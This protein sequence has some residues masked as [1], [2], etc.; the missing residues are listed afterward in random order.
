[1][2]LKGG[3]EY[4]TSTILN[5][6]SSEVSAME[7]TSA[8]DIT[9]IL[10]DLLEPPPDQMDNNGKVKVQ[11]VEKNNE[12]AAE[13]IMFAK[14]LMN[15]YHDELPLAN[16]DTAI[17]LFQ[18][19]L[20]VCP[21]DHPHHPDVVIDLASALGMR[22]V[23]TNRI[24]DLEDSLGLRRNLME[25]ITTGRISPNVRNIA[26]IDHDAT[27]I[28]Q[29]A[30]QVL[31][32]FRDSAPPHAVNSI[33]F[34]LQDVLT[35]ESTDEAL[36]FIAF[37]TLAEGLFARFSHS[38]IILDL[39][40]AISFQEKALKCFNHLQPN[41]WQQQSHATL[42]L[43][44]MLAARF[45]LLKDMDDLDDLSKAHQIFDGVV[46]PAITR[47]NVGL[48]NFEFANDLAEQFV[49]S[50]DTNDLNQ[51]IELF[52]EANSYFLL[53]S[54]G[55]TAT[56]NNLANALGNRFRQEG[57]FSDLEES[58]KL[59]RN[60]LK[61][62]PAHHPNRYLSLI[63]LG[64]ALSMLFEES[65]ERKD[66][67]EA[68]SHLRQALEA[69]ELPDPHRANALDNI[70]KA[71]STRFHEARQ[72]SDLDEAISAHKHAL[73]LRTPPDPDRSLT[74]NGLGV[75]VMFRF[76]ESDNVM[77]LNNA[78]S[79][80]R[81][82]LNLRP[83]PHPLRHSSL[84]NLSAALVARD[85]VDPE[86][87]QSDL[88]EAI[89]YMREGLEVQAPAHSHR[90]TILVSLADALAIRF[91]KEDQSIRS[92]DLLEAISLYKQ[93][94]DL[95]T[96]PHPERPGTLRRLAITLMS[97]HYADED[98]PMYIDMAMGSF[99]EAVNCF[100]DSGFS[101]HRFDIAK[102]WAESADV[103]LH[104]SAA[105]A[106]NVA[107][108]MLPQI[109]ALALNVESR[110]Q[111]LTSISDGLARKAARYF[112][113]QGNADRAIEYL[114]AGRVIFWSQILHLRSPFDLL[115][116][117]APELEEKLRGIATVLEQA[118][119][120]D[121]A[122]GVMDNGTKLRM[123]EDASRLNCLEQEWSKAIDQVR[124][125]KGFNDFLK[126]RGI[127]SLI[128]AAKGHPIVILVAN[129]DVSNCM[130]MTATT[131]H[132]LYL[133]TLPSNELRKL[134]HLTQAAAS[135]TLVRRSSLEG[136]PE[137][138]TA[139]NVFSGEITEALRNWLTLE[140][141]ERG[142][143]YEN[144]KPIPSEDIFRSVLETLW[145][146]VVKPVIDFLKLQKTDNPPVLKWCPTGPFSFLPLHGAGRYLNNTAIEC[147]SDY[148]ISSYTPTIGML[149]DEDKQP[150]ISSEPFQIMAVMDN[151]RLPCARRELQCI[152]S[153][154][155]H[156]CLVEYGS[157]R[158]PANVDAVF[159]G[160]STASIVHF[161]CHGKQDKSK[162]LNS[163]LLLEDGS[164]MVSKIM[165]QPLPQGSL[166]FLSACETGT[167]DENL[168]DEA[169]SLGACLLFSGFRN[170]VA[171]M[172]EMTDVDGPTV[173]DAFYEHL[174]QGPDGKPIRR[175]DMKKSAQA[176]HVSVGKLRSKGVSFRRWLPFIHMGK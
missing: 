128:S 94:V 61:L 43:S 175:P 110:Q 69:R 125:L 102:L 56:L 38:D 40:N 83:S 4:T 42:R 136:S 78:I 145:F 55:D 116:D 151:K 160:L 53:G 170:V 48:Y 3:V 167:G 24:D 22:F 84:R 87:Q 18:Q 85:K 126:P 162:P 89:R 131:G 75:A 68:I 112:I 123:E 98:N 146:K 17:S 152:K 63:G 44:A 108:Q 156:D 51:A 166:A 57:R 119:H 113:Q 106:Y 60:A 19:A 45:D 115:H 147:A 20:E 28:V 154:V 168:P 70:G 58:I 86:T 133:P 6:L 79:W 169:M 117:T 29:T 109:A 90:S 11:V 174:F 118:S 12:M 16:L 49:E 149:L 111:S 82:A 35:I 33:I 176:L 8:G 134:V 80:F 73:Q 64:N 148:F 39:H 95:Q 103:M 10:D 127:L 165:Q 5:P 143:K 164:L 158:A 101:F 71:L 31:H 139:S 150:N 129:N 141:D 163:S 2:R 93:A 41:Q 9:S 171:T 142:M 114:E 92:K 47:E 153:R 140:K 135:R 76:R 1:M 159:S 7:N 99:Q 46:K 26:F 14:A 67:D 97:A 74:L 32:D 124:E 21:T 77:D 122:S 173:A 13:Y 52:R 100:S 27:D 66:L 155:P 72:R 121:T 96:P 138:T 88:N 23:H 36:Q 172:W 144:E 50:G 62:R 91:Q 132:C 37:I 65:G 161:A 107:L 157:A 54:V 59:H 81:E 104:P 105:T 130:I 30:K 34:L 25:A 120:R 137:G 15:E